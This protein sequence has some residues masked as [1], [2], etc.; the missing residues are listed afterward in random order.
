MTGGSVGE[1]LHDVRAHAC[2]GKGH[3]FV[4]LEPSS[5]DE[6][7]VCEHVPQQPVQ[8][9]RRRGVVLDPNAQPQPGEPRRARL[10]LAAAT[11]AVAIP[12]RRRA[13]A[14]PRSRISGHPSRY[15]DGDHSG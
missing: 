12:R 11:S 10:A 7:S 2:Y 13:A 3:P 8:G 4:R 14:T 6:R 15:A 9:A 5:L 1:L